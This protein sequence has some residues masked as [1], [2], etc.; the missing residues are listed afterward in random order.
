M[1]VNVGRGMS[2]VSARRFSPLDLSPALWLDAAD[3]STVIET[4]GSISQWSDKSG[5]GYHAVQGTSSVQPDYASDAVGRC[6]QFNGGN[7]PLAGTTDYFQLS[8]A[9]SGK[10][11]FF[12]ADWNGNNYSFVLGTAASNSNIFLHNT[13]YGISIDGGVSD[14]GEW[15][16]GG[17]S[18][19]S[20]GNIGTPVSTGVSL[21]HTI[22]FSSDDPAYP[23]SRISTY[24][25]NAGGFGGKIREIIMFDRYL[26]AS[27]MNRIGTYLANKWSLSWTT[28]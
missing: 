6:V 13:G 21:I 26:N 22:K 17:V 24:N 4:A 12:I 5:R 11:V 15:F 9:V 3:A 20:G 25:D 19:G 7:L 28:I 8:S 27:E 14:L 23:F 1:L 16:V 18:R 2:P 10:T